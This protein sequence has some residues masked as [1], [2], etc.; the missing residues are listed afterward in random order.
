MH[1][2]ALSAARCAAGP[3]T[4]RDVMI[5]PPLPTATDARALPGRRDGDIA[6]YRPLHPQYSHAPRG[7]PLPTRITPAI[8]ARGGSPP[9]PTVIIPAKFA[10]GGS[11]PRRL[12]AVSRAIARG[13]SPPAARADAAQKKKG[14]ISN[15]IL[16]RK[17]ILA[18]RY[19]P[20]G[21]SR[22]TLATGA[23]H[24][25][26][27]YGNRCCYSAMATRKKAYRRNRLSVSTRNRTGFMAPKR[28][29]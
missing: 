5:A 28:K 11:P 22:S 20:T 4:R 25:C 29:I 9:R 23:L 14:R 26:V 27:R 19:S 1:A 15:D 2:A 8:F 12:G 18:A 17:K 6:P 16:P 7:Q 3:C 10:R 21:D 13:G 24:F